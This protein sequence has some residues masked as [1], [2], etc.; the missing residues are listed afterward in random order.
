MALDQPVDRQD[1][2]GDVAPPREAVVERG[3]AR[4]VARGVEAL[5]EGPGGR[6]QPAQEPRRATAPKSETRP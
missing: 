6:A 5:D 1:G 3:E 2:G 4:G